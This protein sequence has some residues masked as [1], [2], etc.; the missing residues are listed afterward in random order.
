MQD[1]ERPS[2]PLDAAVIG[3]R[4]L[5]ALL[6]TDAVALFVFLSLLLIGADRFGLRAGGM[7]LRAVFP[8][9]LAACS[10]LYLRLTNDITYNKIVMALFLLW[11]VAGA[12][13]TVE[14]YDAVKS[15]GYTIW[16]LF[17]FFVIVTLY[18]NY[19]RY[20]PPAETLSLWFLVFRIHCLMI[21]LEVVRNALVGSLAT[22]PYLWFYES[23]YLAVFMTAYFGSALYM[24][25]TH[26]RRFLFDF[27]L[28]TM[29]ML[30]V[31]SATGIFGILF[32]ILINFIAA[33]QR[34]KLIF[35]AL[36]VGGLF[37]GI[38]FLFFRGTLYYD[39]TLGFLLSGH[40]GD[41]LDLILGRAGNRAVRVLVGWQAFLE[42]PW[43][44]I[45]IG[46]DNAYMDK[47][48]YPDTAWHY[49]HAW[50][51]LDVGQPFCNVF[52]SVLGST[53]ILG[54]IPFM[55]IILYAAALAVRQIHQRR[56][57]EATA[58]LIGFFC[59]LAALQ[60]D[61]TVQRYYLWSPL[62]LALGMAAYKPQKSQSPESKE[63]S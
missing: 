4:S 6:K 15:V 41:A 25:L 53:G 14:S 44:G 50:T 20:Q 60:L 29:S 7:T 36:L 27:C 37:G 51:D 54:F 5:V 11:G 58:V 30:L 56:A 31:A 35:G 21:G 17:D 33:R 62:G 38:L 10:L 40:G 12:A 48:P 8:V 19:A 52:V 16:V 39:L 18:Y 63:A 28:A 57:T 24:L 34:V 43:L 13:S 22:R 26:G 23:S 49:I 59:I 61:G 9:L 2:I 1:I 45:G 42:H 47:N 32:S 46:A 3:Q 55:G